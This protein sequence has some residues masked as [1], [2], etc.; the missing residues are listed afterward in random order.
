MYWPLLGILFLVCAALCAVGFYKFVYF[1]SVGYGFAVAG[2]GLTILILYLL[3]PTA[4]P[5][6]IVL[7]QAALFLAYGA[8]LSG[9]L[10]YREIRSASYRA[11]PSAQTLSKEQKKTPIF[12]SV[13]VWLVVAALY[14]AQTSPMLFRWCNAST[15]WVLPLLGAALSVFGLVLEAAADRQKSAQKKLRPG[16]VATEGLYKL[17]RC[18]NYLGEI[19]FWTGVLVAGLST[20]RGAGQWI[21][22]IL[23]WVCIVYI[24][25]NGAQRMEKRQMKQ[26]GGKPEYRAYAEKTPILF[27]F[28]PLYHLNK[29]ESAE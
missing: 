28:I 4:T 24:M 10:L 18:P 3:S 7:L 11:A 27:P 14:A 15:D 26:Y 1:L 5:L 23:S 8:R 25:V 6:W 29:Q 12:V 16:M 9:F 2:G 20:Y 19:L 17:V 22:A 13:T 21:M